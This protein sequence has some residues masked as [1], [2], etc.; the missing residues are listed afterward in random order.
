[1]SAKK[2]V[3][4]RAGV[5]MT[6]PN[7]AIS[8]PESSSTIVAISASFRMPRRAWRMRQAVSLCSSGWS[9]SPDVPGDEGSTA[10]GSG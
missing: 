1:M 2:L 8:G 7:A 5:S 9:L 3:A 4:S 10:S 6:R